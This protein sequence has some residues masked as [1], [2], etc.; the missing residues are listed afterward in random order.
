MDSGIVQVYVARTKMTYTIPAEVWRTAT[1]T[2]DQHYRRGI[3]VP[4]LA[5][6]IAAELMPASRQDPFSE[7]RLR[8]CLLSV[9][10]RRGVQK[11]Q[12]VSKEGQ[13]ASLFS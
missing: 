6:R 9:K 3:D 12:R 5:S 10:G 13:Q 11:R 4:A 8:R 7:E 1:V 2:F